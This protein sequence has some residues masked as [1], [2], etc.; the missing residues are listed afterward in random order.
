[1]DV[2]AEQLGWSP[3]DPCSAVHQWIQGFI[4]VSERENTEEELSIRMCGWLLKSP[5]LPDAQLLFRSL[6]LG[7]VCSYSFSVYY[8]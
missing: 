3:D 6:E 4:S 5:S 7:G 8:K 1:M 2:D